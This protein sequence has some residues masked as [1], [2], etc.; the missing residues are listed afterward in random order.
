MI[1][2]VIPYILGPDNGLELKYALRS[3]E[4]YFKDEY[5]IC[6]IGDIPDWC[7]N[8]YHIPQPP[9]E[10]NMP[11]VRFRDT[12][13]KLH[14]ACNTPEI[15]PDFIYSYDDI[16]L[17]KDIYTKDIVQ[18]L[19][20]ADKSLE[21]PSQ[22]FVKSDAGTNWK[23]LLIKTLNLLREE[24]KPIYN[25]E[26]HL[27]RYYNKQ[28]VLKLYKKYGLLTNPYMFSSLY[29]NNYFKT[30]KVLSQ[31]NTFK[32]GIYQP[33]KEAAILR[34][35]Q[36]AKIMNVGKPA[37]NQDLKS[38]LN[39]LF[40]EPSKYEVLA[41]PKVAVERSSIREQYPFLNKE[42][43]PQELKILVSDKISAYYN[44]CDAHA[45]LSACSTKK[46][47]Y[48]TADIVINNFIENRLIH[49]ELNHYLKTGKVLGKNPIFEE[50]KAVNKLKTMPVLE[51][52]KYYEKLKHRI[53]RNDDE[54][55]KNKK[56]YLKYKR[57][58]RRESYKR[59]LLECERLLNV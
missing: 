51:L 58:E 9:I 59:E 47:C 4:K 2:I 21:P 17:L 38:A 33:L 28:R 23:K 36:F 41:S 35:C 11:F 3:F 10:D 52:Y 32:A 6:L 39:I 26:T 19:A 7:V 43:C 22:W 34:S 25:C 1:D 30:I 48:E 46:E 15:S 55:K 29:F 8:V 57:E 14:T 5:K 49:D 37:Y 42:N 27:P 45:K 54:I 40:P 50:I 24:N 18:P 44:Y 20:I 56:P 31:L 16:Y 12:L 53:W 13:S